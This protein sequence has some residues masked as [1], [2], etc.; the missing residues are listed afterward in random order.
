MVRSKGE[1]EMEIGKSEK[2]DG[3]GEQNG[4]GRKSRESGEES[5]EWMFAFENAPTICNSHLLGA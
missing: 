5:D 3:Q 4:D 1:M 2:N